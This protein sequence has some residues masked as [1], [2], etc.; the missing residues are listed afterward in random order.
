[1]NFDFLKKIKAG[2]G[3]ARFIWG[4]LGA[5]GVTAAITGAA[6]TVGGAIWA[7]ILGVPIPVAIM[8]G[9]CSFVGTVYLT[10]MP[11]AWHVL[12]SIEPKQPVA[13]EEEEDT[14]PNYT[15]LRHVDRFTLSEAARLWCDIEPTSRY[16]TP[17]IESWQAALKA[18]IRTGD[19]KIIPKDYHRE[20]IEKN[21]PQWNTLVSKQ[22][23]IDFAK[24]HGHSPRFVKEL[25]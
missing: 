22:A 11:W 20:T 8:A 16:G 2:W 5:L 7:I 19:L 14:T 23:L 4:I 25:S 1:M 15:S 21:D 10:L 3:W 9:F 13:E 24:R 12:R 18:A 17:D 6:I